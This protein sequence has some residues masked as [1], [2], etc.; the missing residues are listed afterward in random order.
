MKKVGRV[1]AS[2][3]ARFY[4]QMKMSYHISSTNYNALTMFLIFDIHYTLC[5]CTYVLA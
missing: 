4:L 5:G 3:L 2:D 1:P